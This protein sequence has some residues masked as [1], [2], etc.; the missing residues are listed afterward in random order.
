MGLPQVD[1]TFHVHY[2]Y[3][4]TGT[5]GTAYAALG[6]YQNAIGDLSKSIVLDPDFALAYAKRSVML[7]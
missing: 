7:E 4:P 2:L 3:V 6:Q 1:E 5:R